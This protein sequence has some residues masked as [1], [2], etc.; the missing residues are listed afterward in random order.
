MS[1]PTNQRFFRTDIGEE[2]YYDGTR[3]RSL[4]VKTVAYLGI[5]NLYSATTAGIFWVAAPFSGTYQL[6]LTSFGCGF[7]VIGGATAL[8]ASNKWDVT[9]FDAAG[10]QLASIPIASGSSATAR[11]SSGPVNAAV[12]TQYFRIDVTKTGTPGDLRVYPSIDY[13]I[14]AT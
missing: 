2:F 1:A 14:I 6:W 12:D 7:L 4:A 3:W 11:A 5:Q 13:Q 9:L 8:D 10:T